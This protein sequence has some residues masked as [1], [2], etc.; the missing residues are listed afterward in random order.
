[1]IDLERRTN[2]DPTALTTEALSREVKALKDLL[3]LRFEELERVCLDGDA[4]LKNTTELLR[5]L[6]D[7]KFDAV[8]REMHLVENQRIEQKQD[9][10]ASLAAALAAAKEAVK[11][12]TTAS[13]LSIA[14]SENATNEQLKQL[15]ATFNTAIE[16]VN[17]S[18]NDIKERVG[19]IESSISSHVAGQA[20][21]GQGEER[22]QGLVFNII[23]GLVA[24]GSLVIAFVA[25]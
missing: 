9:A 23:M 19:K 13:G 14:K 11:E 3:T 10:M 17:R 8:A 2:P 6:T 24:I 21:E 16:G 22:N 12:Q 4:T 25:R 18:I 15:T 1:M 5:D 7:E 20:G